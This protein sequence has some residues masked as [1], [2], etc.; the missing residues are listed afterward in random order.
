MT[1]NVDSG[2][3]NFII[4][5]DCMKKRLRDLGHRTFPK[6]VKLSM[7]DGHTFLQTTDIQVWRDIS[8]DF[9]IGTKLLSDYQCILDYNAYCI[10]F[11]INDTTFRYYIDPHDSDDN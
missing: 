9:V 10:Y 1:I 6:R 2:C 7:G 4:S 11:D 5:W 3:D 8:Y